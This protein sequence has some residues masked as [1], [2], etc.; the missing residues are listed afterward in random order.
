MAA[1]G[2]GSLWATGASCRT[3]VDGLGQFVSCAGGR[4]CY[5]N[6]DNSST[7]PTL[8]VNDFIC[9]LN[10]FAANRIQSRDP[11]PDCNR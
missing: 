8:N 6:C 7:P 11:Y 2:G 5:V 1:G 10:R 9:F 3:G 4:T